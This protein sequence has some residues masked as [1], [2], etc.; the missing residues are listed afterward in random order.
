MDL[1]GFVTSG[2]LTSMAAMSALAGA[3]TAPQPRCSGNLRGSFLIMLNILAW[4]PCVAQND[5]HFIS[6]RSSTEAA[7]LCKLVSCNS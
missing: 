4:L 2:F 7:V 5:A 6:H 1:G 3:E